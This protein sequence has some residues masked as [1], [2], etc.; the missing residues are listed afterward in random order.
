[1]LKT[2]DFSKQTM[3]EAISDEEKRAR[4]FASSDDSEDSSTDSEAGYEELRKS[5]RQTAQARVGVG[6]SLSEEQI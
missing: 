6:Q 4:S 2:Y 5:W 3:N 1:M